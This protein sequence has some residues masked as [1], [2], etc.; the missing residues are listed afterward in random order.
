MA[1]KR[2][3]TRNERRALARTLRPPT[4]LHE[5]LAR[6]Y[7][8]ELE[9]TYRQVRKLLSERSDASEHELAIRQLR[10][11]RVQLFARLEK[12]RDVVDEQAQRTQRHALHA[13]RT[14][15][16]IAPKSRRYLAMTRE[17]RKQNVSLIKSVAGEAL[18]RL[19]TILEKAPQ[20]QRVE[21]LAK[22]LQETFDVSKSKA[23]LIARDQTLKLNGQIQ[24][25]AQRAAGIDS[26]IWT[27]V[28]DERVR[29]RHRDLDGTVQLWS[30]PPVVSD[31][32]RREHP[33]G[34]YQCRCF[35]VPVL[36]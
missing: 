22:R 25:E 32:G 6:A 4:T 20:G 2:R 3:L 15:V 16:G 5:T 13:T 23:R 33:G 17:F 1:R 26:Y 19:G 31:D 8:R 10:G 12:L 18:D 36:G 14:V 34:D 24:K 21:V 27:T 28:S 35:A 9:R 11:I 29:D 7:A 30:D